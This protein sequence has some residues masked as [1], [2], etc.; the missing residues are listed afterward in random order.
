MEKGVWDIRKNRDA[1]SPELSQ[2]ESRI[3]IPSPYFP[4]ILVKNPFFGFGVFA[5]PLRSA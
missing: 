1:Y 4:N 5:S 3:L 2:A